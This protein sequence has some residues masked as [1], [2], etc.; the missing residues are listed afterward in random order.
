MSP[1]IVEDAWT[2]VI[3]S[4]MRGVSFRD[5]TTFVAG[6]RIEN[7]DGLVASTRLKRLSV[8][9]QYLAWAAS[10]AV[11]VLRV[12]HALSAGEVT[13]TAELIVGSE[14]DA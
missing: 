9:G 14:A 1:G 11:D 7:D 8:E 4:W 10:L 3:R 12:E 13:Q 5:H 2:P 6:L